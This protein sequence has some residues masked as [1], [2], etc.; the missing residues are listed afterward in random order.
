MPSITVEFHADPEE[1]KTLMTEAVIEYNLHVVLFQGQPFKVTSCSLEEFLAADISDD[2]LNRF[3][4]GVKNL[5]LKVNSHGEFCDKNPSII[6]L[7]IGK[8]TKNWLK[9]STFLAES[10][11]DSF[12]K[13]AR[14]IARKFKK[15]T[16]AGAGVVSPHTGHCG[17]D[18]NIRHT[19]KARDYYS[20]GVK[21]LPFAGGVEF[22]LDTPK[23]QAKAKS[24][25][26]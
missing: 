5:N 26:V 22:L 10:N 4:F 21:M 13:V 16:T 24:R 19:K 18:R 3:H 2:I 1:V 8:L 9:Q 23:P 7:D 15:V 25:M 17:Y 20:Q 11:E 12:L 14:A 6:T